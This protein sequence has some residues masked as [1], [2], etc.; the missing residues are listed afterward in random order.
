MTV[1][2]IGVDRLPTI[3]AGAD[4]DTVRAALRVV[5]A[6]LDDLAAAA[7][8]TPARPVLAPATDPTEGMPPLIP[9]ER[10]A[11][12][13]SLSR[14]AAYRLAAAGELPSRRLGGRVFIVTAGL[15]EILTP[16]GTAA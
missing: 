10:A 11:E 3:A 13:L 4:L 2:A 15:R 12:L 16:E 14:S 5:L 9:V 1:T 8:V 6:Q 7:R